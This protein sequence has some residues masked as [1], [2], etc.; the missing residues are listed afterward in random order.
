M[1]ESFNISLLKVLQGLK[2][3]GDAFEDVGTGGSKTFLVPAT[4]AAVVVKGAEQFLLEVPHWR[5]SSEELP[6]GD[7]TKVLAWRRNKGL[8][9][10]WFTRD[11]EYGNRWDWEC[12]DEPTHWMPVPLEPTDGQNHQN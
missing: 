2:T 7:S 4:E 11:P 5:L 1:I 9:I 12:A 8:G 6:G 10:A 3:L